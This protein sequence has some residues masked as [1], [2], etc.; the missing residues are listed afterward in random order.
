MGAFGTFLASQI[1]GK[2]TNGPLMF[3]PIPL[4]Y[5]HLFWFKKAIGGR[6]TGFRV[7]SWNQVFGERFNF[8]FN[9]Y[10]L[11]EILSDFLLTPWAFYYNF[12]PNAPIL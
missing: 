9:F 5:R 4:F 12:F 8:S 7:F 10:K 3:T 1:A 6:K 11:Y 2:A